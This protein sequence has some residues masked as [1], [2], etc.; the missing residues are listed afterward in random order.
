MN[1][2]GIAFGDGLESMREVDTVILR[3]SL[4]MLSFPLRQGSL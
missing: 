4:Y 2:D 3:F 1:N